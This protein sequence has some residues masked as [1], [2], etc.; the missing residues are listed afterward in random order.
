MPV[1]TGSATS[2]IDLIQK[3]A[4]WLVGLGWTQDKSEADGVGW[5]AHLHK[6]TNYVNLRASRMTEATWDDEISAGGP[7]TRCA[8]HLYLGSGYSSGAAW[9][10]QPGG[11]KQS[12]N[13]KTVGVSLV[14]GSGT[15]SA[16]QFIDDGNDNI[17]IMVERTPGI[18]RH[19]AWGSLAKFG[20]WSGGRYFFGSSCG[21]YS[22]TL[23][24]PDNSPV[25]VPTSHINSQ[26]TAFA[27]VTVDSFTD[28][29]ASN[30]NNTTGSL[31][32]TGLQMS[33]GILNNG[34][35]SSTEEM[36][37]INDTLR[38]G[39]H[40]NI[41]SRVITQPIIFYVRRSGGGVSALGEIPNM[42]LCMAS[43][44][45]GAS[46]GSSFSIDSETWRVFDLFSVKI[47]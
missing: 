42:R 43:K 29:W 47:V 45:A 22:D 39:L 18:W 13:S 9:K 12:G 36:P 11:P 46:I 27:Q 2:N 40:N 30:T 24:D 35:S 14:T 16:Y 4:A 6:G 5:R 17:L 31:G 1:S 10:D 34:A 32:Y 8:I 20:T 7:Q 19:L 44:L 26:A 41:A 21:Y 23:Y 28:I 25:I 15:I 33:S 37:I 38:T 3:I